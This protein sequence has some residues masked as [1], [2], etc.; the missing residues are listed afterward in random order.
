MPRKKHGKCPPFHYFLNKV[1]S[2]VV[3]GCGNWIF[4]GKIS[5]KFK[6]YF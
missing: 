2:I 3:G 5:I 6:K 4:V 1:N